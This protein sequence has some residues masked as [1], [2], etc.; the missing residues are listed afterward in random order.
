M[1]RTLTYVV[2][3]AIALGGG[4]VIGASNPPGEWYQSL[5]K[6]AF[7]P[8]DWIFGPVWF[9]LYALVGIA[10]ARTWLRGH[11]SIGMLLWA[12]QMVLNFLWSPS[13]FGL[14]MPSAALVVIV[15]LLALIL[16]FV[17]NRWKS[18]RISA[19]L[20]IPYAVWVSFEALLNASI[21]YLN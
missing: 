12:W 17:V 6:P 1:S 14:R 13:F 3:V 10:G 5:V 16:A 18:D 20:F 21:V 8:P 11:L 2:F 4:V 15:L 9:V 19:L 7:N